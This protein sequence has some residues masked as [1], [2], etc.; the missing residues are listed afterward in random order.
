M[1]NVHLSRKR[2]GLGKTEGNLAA[3]NHRQ[4]ESVQYNVPMYTTLK[5]MATGEIPGVYLDMPFTRFHKSIEDY[6]SHLNDWDDKV[7]YETDT[8]ERHKPF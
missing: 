3:Q 7:L 1:W 2:Q 5:S 4:G 8:Y 6:P